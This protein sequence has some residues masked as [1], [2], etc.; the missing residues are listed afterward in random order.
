MDITTQISIRVYMLRQ[1]KHKPTLVSSL[2]HHRCFSMYVIN[3]I[4]L[5]CFALAL[6]IQKVKVSLSLGK[7]FISCCCHSVSSKQN[8]DGPERRETA[9]FQSPVTPSLPPQCRSA[10]P[11]CRIKLH[12]CTHRQAGR[13]SVSLCPKCFCLEQY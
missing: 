10:S 12:I 1:T 13:L 5:L 4:L 7:H 6:P 2:A 3:Y 11:L 9:C 8:R